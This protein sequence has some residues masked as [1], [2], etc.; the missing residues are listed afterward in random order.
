MYFIT[1]GNSIMNTNLNQKIF[2]FKKAF[3]FHRKNIFFVFSFKDVK[4]ISHTQGNVDSKKIL[5]L[6]CEN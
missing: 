1:I 4:N 2:I 5:L 3:L 6:I